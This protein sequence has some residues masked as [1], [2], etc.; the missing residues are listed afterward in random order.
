MG[1]IYKNAKAKAQVLASYD[2]QIRELQIPYQDIFVETSFGRMHLTVCGD[3][4]N[5]DFLLPHF[6][7]YAVDTIGHPGKSIGT[8]KL[9]FCNRLRI[10]KAFE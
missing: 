9:E 3:W 8:G 10:P 7:V 6:H 4:K 2:R 5:C 1:T